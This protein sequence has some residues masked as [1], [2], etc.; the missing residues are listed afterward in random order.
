[1]LMVVLRIYI[2]GYINLL[3]LKSVNSFQR[4]HTVLKGVQLYEAL[5]SHSR[6]ILDYIQLIVC[7]ILD[8]FLFCFYR[9]FLFL[10]AI[11]FYLLFI[12]S[13]NPIFFWQKSEKQE[14]KEPWPYLA[15]CQWTSCWAEG[16]RCRNQSAFSCCQVLYVE[17]RHASPCH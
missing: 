13:F 2:H 17:H 16:G 7:L 14:I 1:M 12:P 6:I 11:Q 9:C 15:S 5:Y 3:I 4:V 10:T 8:I